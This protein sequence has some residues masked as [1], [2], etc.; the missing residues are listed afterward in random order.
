MRMEWNAASAQ[1]TF[2]FDTNN[3]N[4]PGLY[5]FSYTRSV[6][7]STFNSTNSRLFIGGGNGLSFDNIIVTVPEPSAALLG[8]L[9]LL[10]LAATNPSHDVLQ[11]DC[12]ISLNLP[13]LI[14][15]HS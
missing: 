3:D 13:R 11:R 9:A 14:P 8:G 10:R 7:P 12:V 6:L 4:G 2:L 15:Q 5:D 1:A